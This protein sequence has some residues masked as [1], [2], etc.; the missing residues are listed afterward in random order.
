ENFAAAYSGVADYHAWL[1]MTSVLPPEECFLAAKDAATRALALDDKLA[2]AYASLGI[3]TWAYDWNFQESERLLKKALELNNNYAQAHEWY[4]Y[5]CASQD[6][7]DEAITSMN[8][9]LQI[10]PFSPSLLTML[11]FILYNA[12]EYEEAIKAIERA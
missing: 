8:R 11:S 7:Y 2:E 10:D 5:V 12:R 6:R 3:A 9:A 1:G 4:A